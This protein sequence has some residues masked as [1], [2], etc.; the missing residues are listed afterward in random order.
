MFLLDMLN[1]AAVIRNNDKKISNG[2]IKV[3]KIRILEFQL[4]DLMEDDGSRQGY[5][6]LRTGEIFYYSE[7]VHT[8]KEI[9]EIMRPVEEDPKRY[10][11]IR[12]IGSRNNFRIMERFLGTLPESENKR[13]LDEALLRRRPFRNFK[14]ELYHMGEI[15]D[16]WYKFHEEEIRKVA[17]EWLEEEG[18]DAELV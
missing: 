16:Q 1:L 6:D 17:L 10:V 15:Q 3:S 2:G 8:S 7:F 12:S 4:F 18:V 5:L 9:D 14:D 13:R 11:G